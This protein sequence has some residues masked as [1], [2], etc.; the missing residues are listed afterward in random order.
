MVKNHH[1]GPVVQLKLQPLSQDLSQTSGTTSPSWC[2]ISG[3]EIQTSGITM[4]SRFCQLMQI[5]EK[6]SMPSFAFTIQHHEPAFSWSWH[7]TFHR[8]VAPKEKNIYF[9]CSEHHVVKS[10]NSNCGSSYLGDLF[11]LHAPE[12]LGK[13]GSCLFHVTFR[14][15]K[16][17]NREHFHGKIIHKYH[18]WWVFRRAM[19][20]SDYRSHP[21]PNMAQSWGDLPYDNRAYMG[22]DRLQFQ[23]LAT[24]TWLL[25]GRLFRTMLELTDN[26][27]AKDWS[28]AFYLP[29]MLNFFF[30]VGRCSAQ[31]FFGL[32]C[33]GEAF[34]ASSGNILVV[35]DTTYVSIFSMENSTNWSELIPTVYIQSA[36]VILQTSLLYEIRVPFGFLRPGMDVAMPN[37]WAYAWHQQCTLW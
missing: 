35:S 10:W 12:R 33:Q 6:L 1:I 5:A 23:S 31:V 20:D 34:E 15:S 17:P 18:K 7:R 30:L 3:F 8:S 27:L 2:C 13:T 19:F 14:E 22:V 16:Y 26:A 37:T 21:E 28:P 32:W 29:A 4:I 25:L 9:D 11:P 36:I 24:F